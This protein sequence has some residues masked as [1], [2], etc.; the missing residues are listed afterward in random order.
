MLAIVVLG[1]MGSIPGVIIAA[2]VLTILPEFLR[3][4]AEYRML[5]FGLLMVVMMIW[6]P[7]GLIQGKR[8]NFKW[9]QSNS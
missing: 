2:V 9:Q 1:G 7:N 5:M 8:K 4:F 3:E 6:K